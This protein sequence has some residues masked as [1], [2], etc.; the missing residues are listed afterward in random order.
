METTDSLPS[1]IEVQVPDFVPGSRTKKTRVNKDLKTFADERFQ[2]KQLLRTDR[3][4]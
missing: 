3:R 4:P 1:F 2:G